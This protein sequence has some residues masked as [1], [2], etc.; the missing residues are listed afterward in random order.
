M[1][2]ISEVTVTEVDA[3]GRIAT[4]CVRNGYSILWS[5]YTMGAY[6]DAR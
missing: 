2:S 3:I 5:T 6:M 4:L 1:V